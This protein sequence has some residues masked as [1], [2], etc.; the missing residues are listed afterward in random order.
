MENLNQKQ[1]ILL[2]AIQ[3]WK[4]PGGKIIVGVDGYSGAGKTTLV[5]GIER[6]DA[7]IL[8]VNRDDFAIPRKE[9]WDKFGK[10]KTEQEKID[11]V[12][13]ETIDI[14]ELSSF[15]KK[16]QEEDGIIEWTLRN[17]KSGFKDNLRKFSF[18][19]SVLVVEGIF[20]FRHNGVK[21]LFD[22][23]VFLEIDQEMADDKT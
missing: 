4:K 8:P 13:D 3:S 16:F 7:D 18:S 20:L 14:N 23:K 10:A 12:V 6:E 11:V 2:N 5:Q 9:F 1:K 21:S 19:K 17:D 15:L 22:K